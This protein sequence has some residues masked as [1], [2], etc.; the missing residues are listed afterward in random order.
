M[1]VPA[2]P[3]QRASAFAGAEDLNE[4]VATIQAIDVRFTYP[5]GSRPA[6][7]GVSV[8]VSPGE[9]IALVGENGSGKSTLAKILAGLIPPTGGT[10][11]WGDQEYRDLDIT[12]VRDRIAVLFQDRKSVV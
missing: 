2:P 8:R 5:G 10:V 7:D 11:V 6:L 3:A 12:A 9:V 4:P 1:N